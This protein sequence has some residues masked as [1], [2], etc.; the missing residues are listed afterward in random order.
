MLG[1]SMQSVKSIHG[2][3]WTWVAVTTSVLTIQVV[4]CLSLPYRTLMDLRRPLNGSNL[5]SRWN[6][7]RMDPC[8]VS[9]SL[10]IPLILLCPSPSLRTS[11]EHS[12]TE[13][14]F[15]TIFSV[16]PCQ[17]HCCILPSRP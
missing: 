10:L 4:H 11:Q 8:K 7:L 2:V 3:C 1:V 12:T 13:F 16:H 17:V 14:P 6:W 15:R 9:P 5:T